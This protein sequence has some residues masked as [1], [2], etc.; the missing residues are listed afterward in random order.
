MVTTTQLVRAVE[1]Y[2]SELSEEQ[3][4]E[5]LESLLCDLYNKPDNEYSLQELLDMWG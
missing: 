1:N 3:V 4:R 2:V 5:E